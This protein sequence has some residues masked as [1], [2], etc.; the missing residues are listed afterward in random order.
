MKKRNLLAITAL[1]LTILFAISAYA[2]A[3]PTE[4][5]G[6]V[7]GAIRDGF[8]AL[9]TT[10]FGDLDGSGLPNLLKFFLWLSLAALG[11]QGLRSLNLNKGVSLLLAALIAG[12]LVLVMP[13]EFLLVIFGLGSGVIALILLALVNYPLT[14]LTLRVDKKI[15]WHITT[16]AALWILFL[17]FVNVGLANVPGL[18]GHPY[19]VFVQDLYVIIAIAYLIGY[20]IFG[21]DE[22]GKPGFAIS[23]LAKS[24]ESLTRQTAVVESELEEH[25]KTLKHEGTHWPD[26][27]AFKA[28]FGE[29]ALLELDKIVAL[30][31]IELTK[32]TDAALKSEIGL[33]I[34]AIEG[35][36]GPLGGVILSGSPRGGFESWIR[37]L[38]SRWG[39]SAHSIDGANGLDTGDGKKSELTGHQNSLVPCLEEL[40]RYI[41]AVNR[42]IAKQK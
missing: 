21:S 28:N 25:T 14:W 36:G 19:V 17:S 11:Y 13:G 40:E 35:T 26:A 18:S 27:A 31:R 30:L 38:N 29:R 8:Y 3:T 6:S 9:I 23:K 4:G 7:F 1:S 24:I 32:T 37:H 39:T 2:Q 12:G 5:I 34:N 15:W 22:E 41:K 42:Q 33:V 16:V 10:L 20:F